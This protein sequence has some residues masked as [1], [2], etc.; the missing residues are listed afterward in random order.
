MRFAVHELARNHPV[1]GYVENT[2]DGR[3][4][5]VLEGDSNS[6][7]AFLARLRVVGPGHIHALD[8]FESTASGEFSN[9]SIRR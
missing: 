9:F 3:V 7:D 1:T 8:R 5:I 4:C 6:I 2:I